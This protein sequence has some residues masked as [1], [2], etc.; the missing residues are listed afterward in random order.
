MNNLMEQYTASAGSFQQLDE[1]CIPVCPTSLDEVKAIFKKWLYMKDENLIDVVLGCIIA[2]RSE[3]DP[4]WLFV[5]APPGG[6]KT[7]IIRS[8]SCNEIIARSSLSPHSLIS[9]FTVKSKKQEK[10]PSLLPLLNGKV[11]VIKDFTCVISMHRDARE[12]LLGTLRDAYDGSAA[13]AFGSEA[14]TREY[15]A[16]FGVIAGVT[17]EIDRIYSISQSLGER[18]LKYRTPVEE[19]EIISRRATAN[20]GK[21]KEMR[22]ELNEAVIHFLK[23]IHVKDIKSSE[24]LNDKFVKLSCLIAHLRSDVSRNGYTRN[25]EF[26]PQPEVGTRLVKQLKGLA[27]GIALARGKDEITEEE[28]DLITKIAKDTLP[29]KRLAIL[30]ALTDKK[31]FARTSEFATDTKLSTNTVKE[32]LEDYNL[33]GIIDRGGDESHGYT[34]KMKGEI[35]DNFFQVGL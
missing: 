6:T 11:L 14:M 8:L 2:N 16:K 17:P 32:L 5:V 21:E 34:W 28:Y 10:D 24:E 20:M 4:V 1:K 19:R 18:F 26:M 33:L 12:E 3:S 25:V 35:E 15:I 30:K 9:G 29:S 23:T 22:R 27:W 31:D 7:E 13:K